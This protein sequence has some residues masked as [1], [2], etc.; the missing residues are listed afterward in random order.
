MALKREGVVFLVGVAVLAV[1]IAFLFLPR[2][3]I[4]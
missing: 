3:S 2:A 4:H 1:V